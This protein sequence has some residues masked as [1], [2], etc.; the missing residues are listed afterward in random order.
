MRVALLGP[1][2]V[3]HDGAPVLIGGLRL[4][5]LFIRL[6]LEPGRWVSASALATALWDGEEPPAD[7]L[8]ALQSLV[9]RLRRLL[10]DPQLL[11]S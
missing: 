1:L 10:P 2:L 6:A 5:A 8:N 4:R 7:P 3:E 9:S 11:E